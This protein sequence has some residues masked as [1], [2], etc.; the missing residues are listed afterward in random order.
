[1][2]SSGM[3]YAK[4]YRYRELCRRFA[5]V[6]L[7]IPVYIFDVFLTENLYQIKFIPACLIGW[8]LQRTCSVFSE[9]WELKNYVTCR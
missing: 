2:P 4:E 6:G 5:F 3:L 8:F 7:T 9:R 1:M